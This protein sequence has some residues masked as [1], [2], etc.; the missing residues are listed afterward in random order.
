VAKRRTPP[1]LFKVLEQARQAGQKSAPRKHHLVPA[2]YLARWA[3]DGQIRVTEVDSRN[4]YTTAPNKAA[5]ETDVYRLEHEQVDPEQVPPLLMETVLGRLEHT[6]KVVIDRII[7]EGN[8]ADISDQDRFETAWHIASQLTRGRA[9]RQE[10]KQL[11]NEM[12]RQL[13]A[14]ITDDEI[15]E[16]LAS[17]GTEP[18]PDLIA[19]HRQWHEELQA[20]AS[21]FQRPTVSDISNAG[22]AAKEA[23]EHVF[24]RRWVLMQTKPVLVTC[25]EPVIMLS[26]PGAPRNERAGVANAGVLLFP[27]SPSHL[28]AL[29]HDSMAPE[30]PWELDAF[31]TADVNREILAATTRWAFER[32]DREVTLRMPTPPAPPAT[33]LSEE[34]LLPDGSLLARNY[35][36]NRWSS[37]PT[38]PPWPVPRWWAPG[39][40]VSYP[41]MEA[42]RID[43]RDD[44]RGRADGSKG[45]K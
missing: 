22:L 31:E 32:S 40:R 33:A 9:F 15:A 21:E 42:H 41:P 20:G 7:A 36:P 19:E 45:K 4:S 38:P 26:G 35:K 11:L 29:F 34:M 14:G 25:D 1:E 13:Y 5:R 6:A 30:P 43:R 28:L 8:R 17:R 27:L 16:R 37:V 44:R 23:A 10:T 24:A 18:T 12:Y 39:W 3:V 2:S